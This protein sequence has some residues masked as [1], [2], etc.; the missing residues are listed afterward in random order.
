MDTLTKVIPSLL[1]SIVMPLHVWCQTDVFN[2]SMLQQSLLLDVLT[3]IT[4][5]VIS[6]RW[7]IF[8]LVQLDRMMVSSFQ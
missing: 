5:R 7:L 6:T 2:A 8:L 3:S 1:A 4:A